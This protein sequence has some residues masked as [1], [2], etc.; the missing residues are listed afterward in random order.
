MTGKEYLIDYI[1]N[2]SSE[3]I[4]DLIKNIEK[5]TL[6]YTDSR[7]AFINFLDDYYSLDNKPSLKMTFVQ[8]KYGQWICMMEDE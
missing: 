8:N 4:Y 6:S 1:Q 5:A 3:E 7:L 2:H